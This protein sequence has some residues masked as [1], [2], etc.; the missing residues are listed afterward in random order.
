MFFT[1][2]EQTWALHRKSINLT[3]PGL[4]S[5]KEA[6]KIPLNLALSSEDDPVI[7][8]TLGTLWGTDP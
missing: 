7:E 6:S 8:D 5:L 4:N 3:N 2:P 1:P